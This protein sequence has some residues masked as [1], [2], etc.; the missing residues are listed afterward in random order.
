MFSLAVQY[1]SLEYGVT[2]KMLDFMD[3][4]DESPAWIDEFGLSF[5]QVTSFSADNT[6]V[7]YRILNSVFN[8]LEK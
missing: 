6:N 5:D 4:A 7:N 8:C 2:N 3:N 1:F